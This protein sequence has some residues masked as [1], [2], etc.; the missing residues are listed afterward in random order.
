MKAHIVQKISCL[1]YWRQAEH[2]NSSTLG[3]TTSTRRSA[4]ISD[5]IQRK[6]REIDAS[7]VIYTP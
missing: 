6:M 3:A 4:G 7:R 2:P 5:M 1:F